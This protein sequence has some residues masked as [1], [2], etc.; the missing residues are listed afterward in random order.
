MSKKRILKYTIKGIDWE[1]F[2]QSNASYVRQHG[3]DSGAISYHEDGEVYFNS[4]YL[5]PGKVRHEIMHVYVASSGTNSASLTKDQ[6]EELCAEIYESHGP[7][8]DVLVDK[9]LQFGMR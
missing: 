8:M 1:F 4:A 3:N 2:F 7:E 9:L 6:M 5:S